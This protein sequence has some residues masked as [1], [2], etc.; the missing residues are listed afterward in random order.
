M[1]T[2]LSARGTSEGWLCSIRCAFSTDLATAL[3][4]WC[5]SLQLVSWSAV[6]LRE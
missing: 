2:S 1:T 5:S 3:W 6:S 4:L